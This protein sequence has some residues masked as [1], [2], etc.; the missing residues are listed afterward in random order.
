ML[1]QILHFR[2]NKKTKSLYKVFLRYGEIPI[3]SEF[4]VYAY[5]PCHALN[6]CIKYIPEE[7]HIPLDYIFYESNLVNPNLNFI[8]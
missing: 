8:R 3:E 2:M 5:N 1:I 7:L 6:M 4:Y